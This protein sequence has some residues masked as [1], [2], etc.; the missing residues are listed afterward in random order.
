[1]SSAALWRG[2]PADCSAYCEELNLV[3]WN[4]PRGEAHIPFILLFRR[5]KPWWSNTYLNRSSLLNCGDLIA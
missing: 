3:I 1:M 5:H 4:L 2:Y